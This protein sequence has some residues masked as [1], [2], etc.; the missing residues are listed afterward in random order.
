MLDLMC[1]DSEYLGL[2]TLKSCISGPHKKYICSLLINVKTAKNAW[3]YRDVEL[4]NFD[5]SQATLLEDLD[6]QQNTTE[7]KK[8]LFINSSYLNTLI[9]FLRNIGKI[10]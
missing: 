2:S 6:K 10:F 5:I 8:R 1:Y 7:R 3:K 4:G 9:C